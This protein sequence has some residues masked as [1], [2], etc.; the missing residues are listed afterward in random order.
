MMRGVLLYGPPASGKDTITAA[1]SGLD[2][3]FQLFRRIKDGPGR[4]A[5]YRM[6][7][8]DTFDGLL[9]TNALIWQNA[10]Y[11]ARYGIDRSELLRLLKAGRIPVVHAGQPEVID[12]VVE[13]TPDVRWTVID[14]RTD[15]ATARARIENRATG[16]LDA[17]LQAWDETAAL[18]TKD[19]TLDTAEVSPE[20]AAVAIR[21]LVCQ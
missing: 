18:A 8:P 4:T 6:V 19:L 7:S 9:R 13:A 5:G 17:R 12:A 14:L 20:L 1:L 10:R 16:D 11:G 15:R 2:Q 21:D 3:R